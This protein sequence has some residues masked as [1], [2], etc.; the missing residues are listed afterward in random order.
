MIEQGAPRGMHQLPLG[1]LD[2]CHHWVL[3][4]HLKGESGHCRVSHGQSGHI[5]ER[6]GILTVGGQAGCRRCMRL[7]VGGH[8]R[9]QQGHQMGNV[10][11]L[12]P[13]LE[14]TAKAVECSKLL[15]SVVNGTS[16]RQAEVQLWWARV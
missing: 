10:V 14:Y 8:R 2:W 11:E 16:R 15:V 4:L 5:L 13:V 6:W 3:D 9:R 12:V 1:V 7:S